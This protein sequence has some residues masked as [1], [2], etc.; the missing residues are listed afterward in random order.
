M[1]TPDI[2][3]KQCVPNNDTQQFFVPNNDT[4]T[5]IRSA[6]F[7]VTK[8]CFNFTKLRFLDH[9]RQLSLV[10][11]DKSIF[12]VWGPPQVFKKTFFPSFDCLS[13]WNDRIIRADHEYHICFQNQLDN[14]GDLEHFY[15]A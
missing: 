2:D 1:K 14:K 11:Y 15:G 4:S 7:N 10:F 12:C 5:K 6:T 8:N 13:L 9:F 3:G